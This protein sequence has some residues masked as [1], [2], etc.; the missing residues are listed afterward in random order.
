MIPWQSL[1]SLLFFF[2]IYL[3]MRDRER[4]REREGETH[5]E[6]KASSMQGARHRTRSR[7]SRIMS[8]AEGGPKPLS[9][10][11]YPIIVIIKMT[12]LLGRLGGSVG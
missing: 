10:P 8:W 6:G 1:L 3:F 2:K 11:G 4:E 5:T 12:M 9:H 7:V